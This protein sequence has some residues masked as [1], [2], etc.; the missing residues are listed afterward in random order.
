MVARQEQ[1]GLAAPAAEV[2]GTGPRVVLVHG[3]VINAKRQWVLQ[4]ELAS[5]FT[6]VLA[7]R[8]GYPPNPPLDYLDFEDQADDIA[9]LLEDGSHLVGFSYGGVV[10]LLAASRR[11]EAVRSLTVIEPPALRV[12]RGHPDVD[13]LALDLSALFWCG[14]QEVRP[15][16]DEFLQLMGGKFTLP[17]TLPPDLEQGARALMVERPPWD[18]RP[19]LGTLARAPFPKLVVSGAHNPALEAVCDA[20]EEQLGAERVVI[21]GAGHDIPQAGI[22][23]NDTLVAFLDRAEEGR[24]ISVERSR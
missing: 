1:P 3:S 13:R 5:S 2:V 20:L 15:F 19:T 23:F 21:S 9:A 17:R 11:P 16:L 24:R 8:R 18:A 6:L 22:G 14:P 7:N 10:A 4:R 12:A